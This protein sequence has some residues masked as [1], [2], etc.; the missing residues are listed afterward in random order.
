MTDYHSAC[1]GAILFL[2]VSEVEG[3]YSCDETVYSGDSHITCKVVRTFI[4]IIIIFHFFHSFP[5]L[6]LR[7][8]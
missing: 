4:I 8:K 6:E 7:N 3:E 1:G 5:P 2:S